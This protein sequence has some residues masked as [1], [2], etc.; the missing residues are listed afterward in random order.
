MDLDDVLEPWSKFRPTGF[1]VAGL[2]LGHDGE[3]QDWLVGPCGQTR[4]SG[5]LDKSNF[6]A[7]LKALAEVDPAAND[8]QIFRMGHWG[9]GWYE[10]VLVRPGSAAA[11][12]AA[13]TACALADYPVLDDEDYS[14]R[15]N[16][17]VAEDWDW[18]DY[19]D[20]IKML[21]KE[22][23][24]NNFPAHV[25]LRARFTWEEMINRYTYDDVMA[26]LFERL[27]EH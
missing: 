27:S 9:P 20:R 8:Y 1:D 17:A 19:R 24:R 5:V 22:A 10:V 12:V 16:E 21:Q 11:K 18:L 7:L 15:E 6:S 3:Y 25:F 23:R 2:Y 13:E 26:A 14:E 4:D